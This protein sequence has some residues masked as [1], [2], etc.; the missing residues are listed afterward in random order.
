VL[1]IDERPVGP[2]PIAQF[3]ARDDRAG[4]VEQQ[5]QDLERL[6]LQPDARISF[7]QLA[8]RLV[9]CDPDGDPDR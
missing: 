5:L 3:V 1:E 8:R 2:Q 9:Q 7:P 6:L 4:T